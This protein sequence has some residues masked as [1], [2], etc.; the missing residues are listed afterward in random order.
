MSRGRG[1]R[2]EADVELSSDWLPAAAFTTV[3]T[4]VEAAIPVAI[5]GVDD[6]EIDEVRIVHVGTGWVVWRSTE[7]E[8][9]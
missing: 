3:Y 2:I 4:T 1:Y 5:E 9:E 7:E 6:A 8:F